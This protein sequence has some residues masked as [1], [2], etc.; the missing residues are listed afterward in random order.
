MC[1]SNYVIWQ[2]LFMRSR[3]L[4]LKLAQIEFYYLAYNLALFTGPHLDK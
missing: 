2:L 1:M 4:T 3:Y